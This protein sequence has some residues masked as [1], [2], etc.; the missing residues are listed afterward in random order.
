MLDPSQACEETSDVASAAR[1]EV[2][3]ARDVALTK[4][5]PQTAIKHDLLR[6]FVCFCSQLSSQ[7]VF[8]LM[9]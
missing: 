4:V 5:I 7:W 2:E 1:S 9:V 6:C 8:N 3:A